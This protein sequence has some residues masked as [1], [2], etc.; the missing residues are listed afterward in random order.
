[1]GEGHRESRWQGVG[2]ERSPAWIESRASLAG[3][4][5]TASW[6]GESCGVWV[7]VHCLGVDEQ[8]LPETYFCPACC[9]ANSDPFWKL[10]AGKEKTHLLLPPTRLETKTRKAL[11]TDPPT[12]ET[13]WHT[14]ECSFHLSVAQATLMRSQPADHQLRACC[15]MLNDP[16]PFRVHWPLQLDHLLWHQYRCTSHASHPA[17]RTL[18]RDS[19]ANIGQYVNP[20]LCR[21]GRNVIS[22][23]SYDTRPFVLIVQFVERQPIEIVRAMIPALGPDAFQQAVA[24][25]RHFA[26]GGD[27]GD[28]SDDDVVV[29]SSVVSI[30]C[31]LGGTRIIKP[32]RY[33]SCKH[34]G[35]FD[36]ENF[37][38]VNSKARKWQCPI[39][40][41]AAPP[42]QLQEDPYMLHVLSLLPAEDL[43]S[44]DDGI[45][46][47]EIGPDGSWK[48]V[49]VRDAQWRQPTD[50]TPVSGEMLDASC[51][52]GGQGAEQHRKE[53]QRAPSPDV[54]LLDDS[55]D[56]DEVPAAAGTSAGGGSMV[57]GTAS[58]PQ[59]RHD[60]PSVDRG[61]ERGLAASR[62][63]CAE[64]VPGHQAA[65]AAC[66]S[67]PQQPQ[68]V[69]SPPPPP[70]LMMYPNMWNGSA[71]M[72]SD[73]QWQQPSPR[74]GRSQHIPQ[75][76]ASSS[77]PSY[78]YQPPSH[79]LP[80]GHPSYAYQPPSR[81]QAPGH[82][83]YA[84]Q[85]PPHPQA[86][87]HPSYAFQPPPHP[88]APG[89]GSA[90][91]FTPGVQPL[92]YQP[93]YPNIEVG[94]S[95]PAQPQPQPHTG[96]AHPLACEPAHVGHSPQPLSMAADPYAAP[97]NEEQR[98]QP[99]DNLRAAELL[100]TF[101]G[102]E[103]DQMADAQGPS[104]GVPQSAGP[105]QG[106]SND[107]TSFIMLDQ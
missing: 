16:I 104:H 65:D 26:G 32:G 41:Y 1:W 30:R 68:P 45:T 23:L 46:E 13:V 79:P 78:A 95:A 75:P 89:Q 54:V 15:V 57:A 63:A 103:G 8:Q 3:T 5:L 107:F 72:H 25:A 97:S 55:D 87:G 21:E 35:F 71:A 88:Q 52:D 84:Y 12:S 31:P 22:M 66:W 59:G 77:H 37:L 69:Q 33:K 6:Q 7:H 20:P 53:K 98:G 14:L 73:P 61:Q 42:D 60:L 51:S 83:S 44:D 99:N 74:D 91:Y 29:A 50:N 62:G 106:A 27:G 17:A 38:E 92:P 4:L 56:D 9:V 76:S 58:S 36:L 82:P 24:S 86:P 47:I 11:P 81:P 28:G 48:P 10:P 18:G 70:Q 40:K 43:D 85:P 39:C 93:M 96:P 19:P 80:P 2:Y 101:Q 105:E 34:L 100:M 49:G 90:H 94:G 64:E 67:Q 102:G